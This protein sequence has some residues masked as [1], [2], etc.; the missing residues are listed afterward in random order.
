MRFNIKL[1]EYPNTAT[2]SIYDD[3]VGMDE[4]FVRY[5]PEEPEPIREPF[6]N[7]IVT[8]WED[9][10][11]VFKKT[12]ESLEKSVQR[13]KR[14]ILKLIRSMD[15]SNAYFVTLT[16]DKTKVDRHDFNLCCTKTRNWLHN[17]RKREGSE[18]MSFL[19]CPELHPKSMDAWH[20][21]LIICN[22]GKNFPITDSHHKDR[23]GKKIFNVDLWKYGFSTAIKIDANPEAAIKLSHY[24][25]K[26][27]SKESAMISHNKHR[28]FASHNIPKPTIRVWQFETDEERDN[29][30]SSILNE[31]YQTVSENHYDGFVG[32]DYIE[33]IKVS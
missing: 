27:F 1:T 3:L 10:V 14:N 12:Q 31:G 26:Y 20:M 5:S 32:V 4:G 24:I 29:I 7:T 33:A 8:E 11:D 18:N 2:I 17:L 9:E 22:P 23:R 16:F 30:V 13:S 15:L 25:T 6:T 21:H 19:C 28:Y